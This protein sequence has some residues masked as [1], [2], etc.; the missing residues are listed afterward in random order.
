MS[1]REQAR[2]RKAIDDEWLAKGIL[3][4]KHNKSEREMEFMARWEQH[5]IARARREAERAKR[6]VEEKRRAEFE[7]QQAEKRR[8]AEERVRAAEEEERRRTEA[9]SN[10]AE[11]KH[12]NTKRG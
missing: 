10:A 2:I 7:R 4:S 9:R 6:E 3:L 8:Q 5:P 12:D 1:G 11:L